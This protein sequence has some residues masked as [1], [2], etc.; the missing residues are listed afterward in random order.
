[1]ALRELYGLL[2]LGFRIPLT[3]G[4]G[5]DSNRCTLGS[6]RTYARLEPG[7]D[8]T[9]KNWTEAVRAGRTFVTSG[10]LLFLTINDQSPG[11]LIELPAAAPTVRLRAEARSLGPL[12]T[13]EVVANH[14]VVA[15]ARPG[16]SP[17]LLEAELTLPAGGWV[18]ARCRGNESEGHTSPVY[19]RVQ[20]LRPPEEPAALTCLVGKLEIMLAWVARDGRFEND[21]QRERLVNIF[22]SARAIL[23]E[24]RALATGSK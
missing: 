23:I 9:Y 20:G 4:S 1:M 5:K 8:L 6:A 24:R 11:T 22:R 15:S 19:L 12:D 14:A 7:K 13:L 21:A 2:D 18:S 10:P 17:S 16:A 3:A